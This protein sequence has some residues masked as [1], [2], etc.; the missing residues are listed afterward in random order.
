MILL[1]YYLL[2]NIAFGISQSLSISRLNKFVPY[3][4]Y[5]ARNHPTNKLATSHPP[6][7][8]PSSFVKGILG[9][10]T[11]MLICGGPVVAR[12]FSPFFQT[13]NDIPKA[14]FQEKKQVNDKLD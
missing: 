6:A 7:L 12:D 2:V 10:L 14:Y 9:A 11:F 4:D 1:A 5:F 8:K 13:V 3:Q